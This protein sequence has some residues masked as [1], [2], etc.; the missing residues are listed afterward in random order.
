MVARV[1]GLTVAAGDRRLAGPVDL[2]VADGE[3][4]GLVGASGSGKSLLVAALLDELP[5]GLTTT[6]SVQVAG[7]AGAVFQDGAT[8][9]DPLARVGAQLTGPL[10]RLRGLSRAAAR[11]HA[12]G[13]L[14]RLGLPPG[15]LR[16]WP[17]TLSG[18]QRQRVALALALAG[19]PRLLVAD[20]PTTALDTVGQAAV[21]DLLD[22]LAPALVLV[23]HDLAVVA[24]L[25]TRVLVLEDGVVVEEGRPADLLADPRHPLTRD[26]VAAARAGELA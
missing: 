18:G 20:E 17:A 4:V 6:G 11:E 13:V 5:A 24:R 3:R 9:L 22:A 12:A 26:L 14:D 10:R 25:C 1:S 2:A 23:S 21:L 8:A 16:A 15:T 7:R 19:D